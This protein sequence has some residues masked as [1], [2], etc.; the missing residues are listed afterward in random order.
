MVNDRL[1]FFILREIDNAYL[2][3]PPS[4]SHNPCDGAVIQPS[5]PQRCLRALMTENALHGQD[6][7]SGVE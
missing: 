1:H 4:P 7:R 6:G 3:L 2:L 5:I